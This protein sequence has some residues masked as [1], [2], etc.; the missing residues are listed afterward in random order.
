MIKPTQDHST[1]VP[2]TRPSELATPHRHHRWHVGPIRLEGSKHAAA[3]S[4]IRRHLLAPRLLGRSCGA[5]M[6]RTGGAEA[7]HTPCMCGNELFIDPTA[8]HGVSANQPATGAHSPRVVDHRQALNR[9]AALVR[10]SQR[11]RGADGGRPGHCLM[12]GRRSLMGGDGYLGLSNGPVR[13]IGRGP[14]PTARK[15]YAPHATGRPRPP[16]A[17][18]RPTFTL[19]DR[20]LSASRRLLPTQLRELRAPPPPT[21]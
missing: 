13:M 17:R 19:V 12:G 20:L 7:N 15:A 5:I 18:T 21:A 11:I 8:N 2:R 6:S 1:A 3:A 16:A 4:R 14:E 10:H 9:P